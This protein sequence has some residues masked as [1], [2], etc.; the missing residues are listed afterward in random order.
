M[1]SGM[2]QISGLYKNNARQEV[3]RGLDLMVAKGEC[4]ALTGPSGCGKTTL[5]RLLAGFEAPDTGEIRIDGRL[6]GSNIKCTP[7]YTRGVAMVF[8]D[9]ALWPHMT[10]AQHLDFTLASQVKHRADREPM[11]R[12]TL[13]QVKLPGFE[14]AHP[15]QLSGGERQRLAIARAIIAKPAILL[16]DEPLSSLNVGLKYDLLEELK[17]IIATSGA[18]TIYVTHALDEARFITDKIFA[19][20]AGKVQPL[21]TAWTQDINTE[22]HATALETVNRWLQN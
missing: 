7:P 2:I 5:L 11:I 20:E 8:Q 10:A 18:T 15:H 22:G 6:V 12:R 21:S 14:K 16:L 9:L 3:L 4:L 19:M 13:A 1:V 17:K